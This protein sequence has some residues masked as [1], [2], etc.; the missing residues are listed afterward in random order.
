M[1]TTMVAVE[2]ERGL[3]GFVQRHP[4]ATFLLIF[5]TFGQALAFIP[6]VASKVYGVQLNVDIA[7]IIP[8]L[9]FLLLPALA[10]TRIARAAQPSTN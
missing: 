2:P 10:I 1:T 7:L 3:W 8:T 9:L 6:V 4:Y 5:N